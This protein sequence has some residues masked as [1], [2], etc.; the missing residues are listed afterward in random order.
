MAMVSKTHLKK[1]DAPATVSGS[2]RRMP[3]ACKNHPFVDGNKRSSLVEAELFLA[4]N[5]HALETTD[6]ECVMVWEKL[7]A[8]VVDERGLAEWF[9]QHIAKS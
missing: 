2:P 1:A 5:R 3:G 4:L 7:A 8:G 6:V 9:K